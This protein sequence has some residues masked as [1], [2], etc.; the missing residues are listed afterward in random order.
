MRIS[1]YGAKGSH[2][3]REMASKS[4]GIRAFAIYAIIQELGQPVDP[5]FN[6][7]PDI[8]LPKKV[9]RIQ[10]IDIPGSHQLHGRIHRGRNR[11][12]MQNAREN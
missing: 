4:D 8:R 1:Y 6:A 10:L 12:L 5:D 3:E 11:L 7:A 2:A 9:L